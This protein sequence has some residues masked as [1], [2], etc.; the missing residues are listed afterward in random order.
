MKSMTIHKMD[1]LLLEVIK[2]RADA[3]GES[4]NATMKKLLAEAV[5]LEGNQES[6]AGTSG[7]R[8]FLGLWTAEESAAFESAAADFDHIDASDWNP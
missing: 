7:Y 5:G 4:I 3:K 8:Q 6:A 1:D 2:E